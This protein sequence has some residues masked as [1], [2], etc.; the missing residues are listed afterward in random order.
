MTTKKEVVQGKK[1]TRPK[2]I[3]ELVEGANLFDSNGYSMVMITKDGVQEPQEL[4]IR[5]TGVSEFMNELSEK[6]PRPP[7]RR[8]VIKQNSAQGRELGLARDRVEQVFDTTDEDYISALDKHNQE[9]NWR[10]VIFALNVPSWKM[11]DGSPAET[12]EDKKKILKTNNITWDH[13]LK[14]F[15]DVKALTAMEEDREDFLP[16]N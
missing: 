13:I 8:V 7:T 14:V 6:A 3:S 15:K 10:V 16:E 9:F 11:K 4:P 5:S 1:D 2:R 12:F